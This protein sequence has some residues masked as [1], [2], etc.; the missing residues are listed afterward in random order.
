MKGCATTATI[1]LLVLAIVLSAAAQTP[2]AATP[3][4]LTRAQ[5][6]A[7]LAGD[8]PSSRVTMLVQER[9]VN[10]EPNDAFLSQVRKGGGEDDLVA[11]LQAAHVATN[12]T[13]TVSP[14]HAAE[15][16]A[17]DARQEEL[18]QR[19]AEGAAFF[20]DH[21]YPEAETAYRAAIKLDPQ[22][23]DLHMALARALNSQKKT[24]EGMQEAHLAVQLNPE[25]DMAHFAL[26]NSLRMEDDWAGAGAEFREAIRLNPS[27]PMSHNNLGIV[28]MHQN[29]LDGAIGEFREALR[30]NPQEELARVNLGG[31]LEREGDLDGAM[32]QFQELSR[33]KPALAVAHFRLGQVLE[34]KGEPRR[35]VMEFRRATEL[36]PENRQFQAALERAQRAL[37]N[38]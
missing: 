14:A 18:A 22:S 7:L 6:L 27:Y 1:F 2:N 5:I 10:F 19:A 24:E 26:A 31:A 35:A 13:A 3:K 20:Q 29:N 15:A 23:S 34:K 16:K 32:A 38:P 9:G 36:A 37:R 4:P 28:L 30:L 21:R 33:Q 8:I 25:S 17:E 11:A 12:P